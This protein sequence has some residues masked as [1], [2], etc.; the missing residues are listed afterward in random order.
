VT[1]V[2]QS[3]AIST[4]EDPPACLG[5]SSRG[6]EPVVR[7]ASDLGNLLTRNVAP[8]P[9]VA[10]L[11][12]RA[13]LGHAGDCIKTK[14]SIAPS[15]SRVYSTMLVVPRSNASVTRA[16]SCFPD[17]DAASATDREFNMASIV[18]LVQFISDRPEWHPHDVH[19][20][21]AASVD[22]V[23]AQTSFVYFDALP[24]LVTSA[25]SGETTNQRVRTQRNPYSWCRTDGPLFSRPADRRLSSTAFCQ[26][27]PRIT[28]AP[29]ET[30][31][32]G[33][34]RAPPPQHA[35]FEY[36]WYQSAFQSQTFPARS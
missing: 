26:P 27:P 7:D 6:A 35:A 32:N 4:R 22:E 1:T 30:S 23:C 3:C 2:R 10:T 29:I 31:H 24:R 8:V 15:S 9:G 18:V 25:A 17:T 21:D 12:E 13:K 5:W 36:G 34:I 16:L 28:R 33:F 11:R 19:F 20:H 14:R